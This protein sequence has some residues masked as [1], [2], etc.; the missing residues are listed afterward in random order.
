MRKTI[1]ALVLSTIAT[2][3]LAEDSSN[4]WTG[5]YLGAQGA[6]VG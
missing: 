5:F 1:A 6:R 4:P 2:S 3:A